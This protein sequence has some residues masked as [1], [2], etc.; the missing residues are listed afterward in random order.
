MPIAVVR[1]AGKVAAGILAAGLAFA[2]TLS[3]GPQVATF[4]SEVDDSDQPYGLYVP[5]DFDSSRTYPLVISLHGAYSNHRLN[6][7]RLFGKGNLLGETDAEASRY[8]PRFRDVEYIVAAPYSRG[9]MG[10]QGIPEKDVYDVLADVKRRF[11]IDDDRV[12]LT[13]L[14]MGG[15]GTLWLGLTRPDIWAAIAPVCPAVPP[16]VEE[17][18]GNA[19]NLPVHLFQ[20]EIDPVVPASAVRQWHKRLLHLDTRVEYVEYPGVRHNSW[21]LAYKDGAIFDLFAK[22]KRN[23]YP[24]RV[25][26]ATS[27]YKYDSAYWLKIDGLTPGVLSG[28]D[29]RFTGKNQIAVSTSGALI[30]FTFNLAGHPLFTATRPVIVTIDGKTLRIARANE[31]V[32]FSRQ[33]GNWLAARYAPPK[34]WKRPGSEGPASEVISSRHIYVYGTAG[35]Q[36]PDEL[37]RRHEQAAFGAEW[38]T[39]R[40]KLLLTHRI[41]AD[42][43]VKDSELQ[44]G[45]AVLFGTKETNSLIA[46][47]APSA[48]IELNPGAAGFGL[49]LVAPAGHGSVLI[50]SGLPWWTGYDRVKREGLRFLEG[51]YTVLNSFGDFILFRG[52]LE[53]VI[54]EGRFEPN[55]KVPEEAAAKM[56]A[57]GAVVVR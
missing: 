9:T 45:R 57:T 16:G 37:K 32:S 12:Y 8:F 35:S 24:E 52:S 7:R 23:R 6:I 14:S 5:K 55:W 15:G 27:Q 1:H 3:P 31:P 20:G 39:S 34:G 48:P 47:L 10:Y 44:T 25:R 30:G 28:I 13:G 2:Q 29:A 22:S 17:L 21:D 36:D 4:L 33:K 49:I 11:P 51:P 56:R 26:F 54:A 19:L 18:A 40:L 41:A 53:N 50:N 42:R 43:D 46:K 38:S